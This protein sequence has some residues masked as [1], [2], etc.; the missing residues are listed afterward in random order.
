MN[1]E[2]VIPSIEDIQTAYRRIKRLVN[3]TPV[4]TSSSLNTLTGADI[5]FKCENFQKAGAFK[6][7]GACHAIHVLKH[8]GSP[9]RAVATHSSGNHAG[10]LALAARMQKL[11]CYVVMPENSPAIKINAVRSY[12][13]EITFC[14]PTLADREK[15]IVKVLKEKK[16]FFIHPY[17]NFEVIAGQG[18]T[19]LEL[20]EE[21]TAPDCIIAPVGGGGLMSGTS[22]AARALFRGIRIYGAEPKGADDACRSLKEK[23]IIPSVNPRTICDGLLTSLG[24]L[25]F[26]AITENVDDILTVNEE[27]IKKAMA[28][29]WA[30]MKIVVEPSACVT[31]AAVLENPELFRGKKTG[32]ILSGGN[33]DISTAYRLLYS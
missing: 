27:S 3:R 20:A 6:F 22:I 1:T 13:A 16:A 7:R 25:T 5:Y 31:L 32:L 19:M 21:L 33:I 23:R 15:G 17:N 26:K 10:A 11:N 30:R 29:I 4:M 18:T 12:G 8:S 14:P 24:T 2:P 28:L 9:A